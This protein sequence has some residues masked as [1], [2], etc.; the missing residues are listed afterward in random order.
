MVPKLLA[1]PVAPDPRVGQADHNADE[2]ASG[3]IG[4]R[5]APPRGDEL[6]HVSRNW[7]RA[8]R[9]GSESATG[10]RPR[11]VIQYRVSA[12]IDHVVQFERRRHVQRAA[13]SY[14]VATRRSYSAA[15]SS[16]SSIA[17]SRSRLP[18]A[19]PTRRS[20]LVLAGRPHDG[21]ERPPRAPGHHRQRPEGIALAQDD[22]EA[23]RGGLAPVT[24]RRL[25]WRTRPD[26]STSGPTI[27]PGVST[28]EHD[29]DVEGVA[30]LPETGR[31]FRCVAVDRPAE[32]GVLFAVNPIGWPSMPRRTRSSPRCRSRV[33]ARGRTGVRQEVDDLA[34]VERAEPVLRD[35][36]AEPALIGAVPRRRSIPWKYDRTCFD[37]VHRP[38]W[39]STTTSTVPPERC[40]R[41]GRPPRQEARPSRRPRSW[42]ARPSR[43]ARHA[44]RR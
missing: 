29:R 19:T 2:F 37:D 17:A 3:G 34:D 25:Q 21:E 27:I 36:R 13:R 20:S 15:R 28:S 41:S 1:S 14:A 5:R 33:A 16:M 4:T 26:L 39:S 7:A 8:C 42:P 11:R 6:H 9:N 32:V 24:N 10:S 12:G 44:S 40:R 38:A 18:R 22:R 31:S 30:Q 35:D 43:R 23:R